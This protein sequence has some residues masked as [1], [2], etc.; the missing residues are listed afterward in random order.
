MSRQD[1]T[2]QINTGANGTL[3]GVPTAIGDGID[4][5]G[6][7]YATCLARVTADTTSDTATMEV[8]LGYITSAST[9]KPVTIEWVKDTRIPGGSFAA[10]KAAAGDTYSDS[11]KV[12]LEIAGADRLYFRWAAQTDSAVRVVS[13]V[14]LHNPSAVAV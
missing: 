11:A 8:W 3:D 7:R 9:T 2:Y 6:Y 5:A 12:D 4:C 10:V 1:Q 13:Y 14:R